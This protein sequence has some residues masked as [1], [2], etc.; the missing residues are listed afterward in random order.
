MTAN[1]VPLT[2]PPCTHMHIIFQ[3]MYIWATKTTLINLV[4]AEVWRR[5]KR[6]PN[7][8]SSETHPH[9]LK[10]TCPQCPEEG[11]RQR[12]PLDNEW[13]ALHRR[14]ITVWCGTEQWHSSHSMKAPCWFISCL[15]KEPSSVRVLKGLCLLGLNCA[16][17][18]PVSHR[19]DLKL[20]I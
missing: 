15:L 7:E 19:S 9:R 8:G 18:P 5:V 3:G 12:G 10:Q 14:C 2:P 6:S 17:S 11:K 20:Q 16:L 1:P 13:L 4:Q